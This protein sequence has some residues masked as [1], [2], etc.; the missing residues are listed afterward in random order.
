MADNTESR[1]QTIQWKPAIKKWYNVNKESYKLIYEAAKER[2]EEVS[3]ESESITNK[4]ITMLTAL[5]GLFGFF[6]GTLKPQNNIDFL[7]ALI[8]LMVIDVWYLF[9][10]I[11][12]KNIRQRGLSP[13]ESIPINLDNDEDQEVQTELVYYQMIVHYENNTSIMKSK[14]EKRIEHFKIALFLFLLILALIASSI[15]IS[16]NHP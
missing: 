13:S 15:A 16:V 12:P 8:P 7:W 4:S 2:F 11:A 9:L 14:N 3:S 5:I 6:I 1:P 10:L